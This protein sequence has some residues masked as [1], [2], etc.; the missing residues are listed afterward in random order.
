[1]NFI[2]NKFLLFLFRILLG[3][4]FIYAGI[5]KIS[6]PAAFSNAIANY[7]L[8][9]FSL[10]NIFAITLPWVEVTAGLLLVFGVYVKENSSII[11][12]LLIVFFIAIA[13]SL[14]RGLNIEC[15]CFG[16]SSGAKVGLEKLVENLLLILISAVLTKFGSNIFSL[17]ENIND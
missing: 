14:A 1:M 2:S 3:F 4:L 5:E 13:I 9:P 15:G 11:I 10:V 8:L 12:T 7:K 16:T 6:D 17:K